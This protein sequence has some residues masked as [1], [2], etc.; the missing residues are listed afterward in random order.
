MREDQAPQVPRDVQTVKF[1]LVPPAMSH[2]TLSM[3]M[4]AIAAVIPIS[5]NILKVNLSALIVSV[6][7]ANIH[8]KVPTAPSSVRPLHATP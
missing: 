3:L 8:V 4:G 2:V 1:A 7:P 5:I 6:K